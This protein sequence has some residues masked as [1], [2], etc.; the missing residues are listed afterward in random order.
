MDK[1]IYSQ[2]PF[3]YFDHFQFS[4]V[5]FDSTQ[6]NHF[7]SFL[8]YMPSGLCNASHLYVP[9]NDEMDCKSVMVHESICISLSMLFGVSPDATMRAFPPII[10][11]LC[12]LKTNG[13]HCGTMPS[14]MSDVSVRFS[15]V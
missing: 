9:I 6:N 2:M 7:V 8:Y 13:I 5:S 12:D 11:A 3:G 15:I 1:T 4:H 14:N 10:L